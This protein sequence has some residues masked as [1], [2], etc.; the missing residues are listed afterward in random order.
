ML[1]RNL[2]RC[3]SAR[4]KSTS[5]T[6]A[7]NEPP[8][9]PQILDLSESAVDKRKREEY[10]DKINSL[11][12]VEEKLFFQNLN[13]YYGSECYILREGQLPLG[14]LPFAKFATRTRNFAVD[15]KTF[16]RLI[17]NNLDETK[18]LLD[19]IRPFVQEALLFELAGRRSP[20]S[21]LIE[22]LN[23]VLLSNL[24]MRHQHLL[25]STVDFDSR[26]EAFWLAGNFHPTPELIKIREKKK[27]ELVKENKWK[28]RPL[29]VEVDLNETVE[30]FI[31]YM[32]KPVVQLRSKLPLPQLDTKLLNSEDNDLE[33]ERTDFSADHCS[34]SLQFG[35]ELSRRHGTNLPGFWP[36]DDNEF[37]LLSYHLLYDSPD[38]TN[39]AMSQ[40][41]LNNYSWLHAQ[42]ALLGFSTYSELTYPLSNQ[43]IITDGRRFF[44]SLYQLNTTIVH[45]KLFSPNT[46]TNL[47]V[48]LPELRLYD[49]IENNR[50]VGWNDSVLL[51][52][53]SLYLNEP[54]SRE[55][56]LKPYVDSRVKLTADIE[57]DN[58]RQWLHDQFRHMYSNRPRHMLPYEIFDWEKIY[59]VD[60]QTRG[61]DAKARPFERDQNPTEERK[62]WDYLP[63]YVPKKFRPKKKHWMG[64]RGKRAKTF[65]PEV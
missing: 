28:P 41:V 37:G 35:L 25:D 9:Y 45:K 10:R 44:F 39:A 50:F 23:G 33:I 5:T 20:P 16:L 18:E 14:C 63:A 7:A 38:G 12:S 65:F 22:T 52:L 26:V 47:C 57:D 3:L 29:K 17:K 49:T 4:Y 51:V 61:L 13:H 48:T 21:N 60:F 34:P 11:N 58:R 27:D 30:H 24:S 36:G 64:W 19:K 2:A 55:V 6:V 53:L 1:S 46:R 59:K 54:Q 62:Y 32:S 40:A 31:Q 42:A 8:K 56:E 43:H 15:E